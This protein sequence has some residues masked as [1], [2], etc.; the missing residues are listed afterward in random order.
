MPTARTTG[1][2]SPARRFA[3]SILLA[4]LA[5]GCSKAPEPA[6]APPANPPAAEPAAESAAAPESA[7]AAEPAPEAEPAAATAE[8]AAD[9]LA[10]FAES[11]EG[12]GMEADE[13]AD[14]RATML[15]VRRANP[16]FQA[17]CAS[18]H[19]AEKADGGYSLAD[20]ASVLKGGGRGPAVVPGDADASLLFQ[21]ASGAAE[22]H[23][24]HD[25][26]G[27]PADEVE[28]IREWIAAGARVP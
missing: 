16:I 11:M 28:A 15:F 1:T 22:F 24:P 18:C 20:G 10:A 7:P 4:T 17:K 19:G 2:E 9:D 26:D 8:P 14:R 21:V 25:G 5:I 6:T 23:K 13:E 27:L 12:S 3:A